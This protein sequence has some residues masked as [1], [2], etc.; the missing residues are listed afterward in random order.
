MSTRITI[1]RSHGLRREAARLREAAQATRDLNRGLAG[2]SWQTYE[3]LAK[4]Q[5]TIE[6]MMPE[7]VIPLE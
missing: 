3:R 6:V 7:G 5:P 4:E 2:S 1:D